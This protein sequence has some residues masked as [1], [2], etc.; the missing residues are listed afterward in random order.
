MEAA[1]ASYFYK[2]GLFCATYQRTVIFFS[3][4]VVILFSLPLVNILPTGDPYTPLVWDS[5]WLN[6]RVLHTPS[7]V[8]WMETNPA[9]GA[10]PIIPSW[11][12]GEPLAIVQQVVVQVEI[13]CI[14][15]FKVCTSR[16]E[17][18]REAA[19][20]HVLLKL[21]EA[22]SECSSVVHP[23]AKQ[24][25]KEKFG[26]YS[27]FPLSAIS[28]ALLV[29][30]HDAS[31]A[32]SPQFEEDRNSLYKLYY[33]GYWKGRSSASFKSRNANSLATIA[34]TLMF[35]VSFDNF[36]KVQTCIN[37]LRSMWNQPKIMDSTARHFF[38]ESDYSWFQF[39]PLG[40]V[41]LIVFAYITFSVG[42]IEQVKSKFGL[43]FT[44][45]LTTISSLTMS[46][47][48]CT[49]FGLSISFRGS[50]IFPYL[51]VMVG[52]EKVMLIVK[53]VV[54]VPSY[55][56]VE[57]RIAEGLSNEG[58][59]IAKNLLAE[60]C[61]P[62]VGMY[63]F[64][65]TIMQEFC[66]IT[67]IGILSTIFLQIVFF[68]TVLSIDITRM[69]SSDIGRPRVSIG[70]RSPNR[71][72][73]REK[74]LYYLAKNR[75]LQRFSMVMFSVYMVYLLYESGGTLQ[76]TILQI[77][78]Y[79]STTN[80]EFINRLSDVNPSP[81]SNHLMQSN[82]EDFL[83]QLISLLPIDLNNFQF[84]GGALKKRELCGV[85][86]CW[87]QMINNYWPLLLQH[88][89]YSVV[90][91]FITYLPQIKILLHFGDVTELKDEFSVLNISPF[92][93]SVAI[94]VAGTVFL[95]VYDIL[96]WW[97][98]RKRKQRLFVM[99]SKQNTS[100]LVTTLRGH[101]EPIKFLKHD[102][103]HL[104][105]TSTDGEI[106]IWDPIYRNCFLLINRSERS[107][108][109]NQMPSSFNVSNA[110]L[111]DIRHR[112][113]TSLNVTSPPNQRTNGTYFRTRSETSL[114]SFGDNTSLISANSV[115]S[116]DSGSIASSHDGGYN[117]SQHFDISSP[118]TSSLALK[119]GPAEQ[120]SSRVRPST[121]WCMD[122]AHRLIG[123]GCN[124]GSIEVWDSTNGNL[125]FKN[126]L[127]SSGI[128]NIVIL[129]KSVVVGRM[130]GYLDMFDFAGNLSKEIKAHYKP[131]GIMYYFTGYIVS[132]SLDGIVKVWQNDLTILCAFNHH[133]GNITAVQ[134][135]KYLVSGCADGMI[136]CYSLTDARHLYMLTAHEGAVLQ[137]CCNDKTI[138]SL[139]GD[140]T[141]KV[142]H[143]TKGVCL[144]TIK[145]K[146]QTMEMTL[147]GS[148]L[149]AIGYEGSVSV[150]DSQTGNCNTDIP[151]RSKLNR[152]VPLNHLIY[153]DSST[154]ACISSRSVHVISLPVKK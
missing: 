138:V 39:I 124:D 23:V 34:V 104:I 1:I 86:P 136:C 93:L 73:K 67:L 127:K 14:Q 12:F 52:M 72:V 128:L 132:G 98:E 45:V 81:V 137:L 75:L 2:H 148:R 28:P 65:N 24:F 101:K 151:L 44:A 5:P 88:Y 153:L 130:D 85:K 147:V 55:K 97:K 145:L 51:V 19:S 94:V 50:E 154:L 143:M 13:D 121:V 144:N 152:I 7:N 30:K 89:N 100:K 22:D 142:W 78:K 10:L 70:S 129:K 62:L 57:I 56:P 84:K 29:L 133:T 31:D 119:Y 149:I 37:T 102:C 41:Y 123:L 61:L 33:G 63:V 146:M 80:D 113:T 77:V 3:T 126:S 76:S 42:K 4:V 109:R 58:W 9:P 32:S 26:D 8:T 74:L 96:R 71:T 25:L 112:S 141:V 120:V 79:S 43:G 49:V 46:V 54:S 20:I 66:V 35:N 87:N 82:K 40:F 68:P 53:A 48:I 122:V 92:T 47:G 117:Y 38:Y 106:R 18:I 135:Y 95:I 131:I 16:Y 107:F 15:Y 99:P 90:N 115:L 139:G 114:T 105:T 140:V 116:I 134:I 6:Y 118:Y 91:R 111:T 11:F 125:V 103:G 150:Y 60:I 27:G 110:S 17:A 108:I 69:D 36:H 83:S 59:Y 64:S 21:K